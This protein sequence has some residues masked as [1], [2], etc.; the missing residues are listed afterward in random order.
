M[1]YVSIIIL[2]L[3]LLLPPAAS[4]AAAQTG[5]AGQF[6]NAMTQGPAEMLAITQDEKGVLWMGT[7]EGL[8]SYDGYVAYAHPRI[9]HVG[10]ERIY[11][12]CRIGHEL[13]LGT[14]NGLIVFDYRSG[15]YRQVGQTPHAPIRS[16]LRNGRSLY[17]GVG[18]Q[19]FAY[20]LDHQSIKLIAQTHAT[21]YALAQWQGHLQVGTLRGLFILDNHR[22]QRQLLPASQ[23]PLVNA[24][25]NDGRS[26][27]IGTEGQLYRMDPTHGG[28][29]YVVPGM[30]GNSVKALVTDKQGNL[31]AGT[32]NGLYI[33]RPNGAIDHFTHDSR[34]AHSLSNNIIWTLFAD[35]DGNIWAG[36]DLGL[37]RWRNSGQLAFLS[38]SDITLT[39][40]GNCLH[41]LLQ[42]SR[43]IVW[44]GGT[45]G[46][47]RFAM[48]N[49]QPTG[50]VWFKQNSATHPMTHNRV[51]KI[52][53]DHEGDIWIAT[54]H[55]VNL[56]DKPSG[57]LRNFIV[58]D[59]SSHYSSTWAYDI[60]ED[61]QHRLWIAAY[62]G[63]IFIVSKQR[64]LSSGGHCVADHFLKDGKGGL[65]N[66]HVGQLVI[67]GRDRVW[68]QL[69][70]KGVDCIDP[71]TLRVS[72]AYHSPTDFITVDNSG[73]VW[74][75]TPTQLLKETG[76]RMKE[77]SS[78]PSTFGSVQSICAVGNNVWVVFNRCLRIMR[79]DGS[80]TDMR[81]PSLSA[82]TAAY[83]PRMGQMLIGGNDALLAI[84]PTQP[85]KPQ[86]GR[87]LL[88]TEL[89][90]NGELY[91]GKQRAAFADGI[92]LRHDENNLTIH[93]TD[94]P[95]AQ[96]ISEVYC[97]R[98]EGSEDR[99][100][101]LADISQGISYNALPY[102]HYRFVVKTMGMGRGTGVTVCELPIRILPPWYLSW[103][104]KTFY[105]LL[106][107]CAVA[108]VV[109]FYLMRRRLEMEQREKALIL[110]QSEGKTRFYASLSQHLRQQLQ[111]I[112]PATYALMDKERI[113]D[114]LQL[115][116]AVRKGASKINLLIH[117]ALGVDDIAQDAD[118]QTFDV[119]NL[120]YQMVQ[121]QRTEL[122]QQQVTLQM[123]TDV[124]H[125]ETEGDATQMDFSF[126]TLLSYL[127]QQA[128]HPATILVKMHGD[129][130]T[131]RLQLHIDCADIQLSPRDVSLLMHRYLSPQRE[132]YGQADNQLYLVRQYIEANGG[133][134]TPHLLTG[135]KG[136]GFDIMLTCSTILL[137]SATSNPI[138]QQS[139]TGNP[140]PATD[141]QQEVKA[142][143]K[144][145]APTMDRV[146]EKFLADVTH[147]IEV[148][149]SDSDFN[150]TALQENIGISNKQLYRKIKQLTGKTPV[151]YLRYVRLHQAASMLR[152]GKYT[153]SEVMY[154]VGFSKP[155]YFSKCFQQAY[156]LTP[157]EYCKETS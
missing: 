1:R 116:E 14:D 31:Y 144:A 17:L 32:D 40:E 44:A 64:L 35:R 25:L 8:Y 129:P 77:V 152:E 156:G 131:K 57:Q 149:L 34:N 39:G 50:T 97:Y 51:R 75:A 13:W 33:R 79:S 24:L 139:A 26:L 118:R 132:G 109:R 96:G 122:E 142:P 71:H 103:W 128:T 88:I 102:G 16:M 89:L 141:G 145:P 10:G 86:T 60:V 95:F 69:H 148:H 9:G 151:E 157:S 100:H 6:V 12:L 112:M 19:L 98:L 53:E 72:H 2:L 21:I 133:T 154:M 54:D 120:L 59:P 5:A 111:H 83:A 52:Y 87:R 28:Q 4:H 45:N 110:E 143:S 43:G 125:A 37:S 123:E 119:A 155:G 137:Q 42:D 107:L 153:V 138:L 30:A 67:D 76:S 62:M 66:I 114:R 82:V 56:Y 36:T 127:S 105:L 78:L 108:G 65:S 115:L 126:A 58:S 130:E 63:G 121:G 146:D 106:F 93:L 15:S 20:H 140:L 29:P 124:E 73:R 70:E 11:S 117:D 49:G 38:L 81:I 104:A 41:A 84:N 47:I 101:S 3:S 113:H 61:G 27:W 46:L 55:G 74:A 18:D 23:Q 80:A 48:T 99:W 90:V 68:A 135:D 22:L 134:I 91:A 147:Q 150:V 92:V 136:L 7:A 85:N 94:L